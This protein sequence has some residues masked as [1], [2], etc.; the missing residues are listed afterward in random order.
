MALV[1]VT[2]MLVQKIFVDDYLTN[3]RLACDCGQCRDDIM[4]LVLNR[5]PSRY[6]STDRGEAYVKAQFFDPQLTSDIV[7]ELTIAALTVADRP[8]HAP[9]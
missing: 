5:M 1:N 6:V 4:A 3:Q 7:R 2:Q 8:N 9:V